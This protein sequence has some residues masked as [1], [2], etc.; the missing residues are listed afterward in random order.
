MMMMMTILSMWWQWWWWHCHW[1][2]NPHLLIV[3]RPNLL[4]VIRSHLHGDPPGHSSVHILYIRNLSE[5]TNT[6]TKT[7]L[8]TNT[9]ILVVTITWGRAGSTD[10]IVQHRC[11]AIC[12]VFLQCVVYCK[13]IWKCARKLR[14]FEHAINSAECNMSDVF[15]ALWVSKS[16]SYPAATSRP[17][18][19]I[20]RYTH[21]IHI[22]RL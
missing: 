12:S 22:I 21:I 9:Y 7:D 19:N 15:S 5:Y 4:V 2:R 18:H 8:N 17:Q 10:P 13:Y 1:L 3:P 20:Q 6:N 16:P 11:R 14:T